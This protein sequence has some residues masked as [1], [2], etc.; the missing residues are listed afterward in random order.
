MLPVFLDLKFIKV[1]T[2]GIFL[3]L[4]FFWGCYLLW[5]NFRLTAYRE[6]DMFDT[7]FI[8][9]LGAGIVG[10]VFY[11]I[12]HF[13]D[14]G[15]NILKYIL[16]NGYPGMMLYGGVIGFFIFLSLSL[17]YKKIKFTDVIDYYIS[18]VFLA[19]AFGKLGSFFA[20][21][22]V[23]TQTK[24]FLSLKYVGY[25]G[26]R[27]LTA[28]YEALL[29]FIGAYLSYRVLFAIRREKYRKGASFVLFIFYFGMVYFMF[30]N[31]KVNRIYLGGQTFNGLM[32]LIFLI[33][34]ILIFVYNIRTQLWKRFRPIKNFESPHGNQTRQTIY[35][36][37]TEETSGTKSS[38]N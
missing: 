25:P 9:I 13:K 5:K 36:H 31:L 27:H 22:E 6:D 14:F 3:V 26:F 11:I 32:S 15:F 38:D 24:F 8:S 29:F 17:H 1:Y 10:R 18:P 7:L 28:F 37:S 20:G 21:S 2:F 30:D 4:A 35:N 19:L 33:G 23:G 34:S 16:I 12:F